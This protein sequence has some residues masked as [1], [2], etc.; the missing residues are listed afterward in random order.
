MQRSPCFCHTRGKHGSN[1]SDEIDCW[2]A[3]FLLEGRKKAIVAK[4]AVENE[5]IAAL[6]H[7]AKDYPDGSLKES[8]VRGW[9]K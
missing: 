1:G 9:K 3:Y 4:Y 7:F 5:I 2:K 6:R 8:T